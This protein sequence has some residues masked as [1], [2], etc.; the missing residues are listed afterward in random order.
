LQQCVRAEVAGED[1]GMSTEQMEKLFL[2][3]A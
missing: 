1:T 2:S 3:L